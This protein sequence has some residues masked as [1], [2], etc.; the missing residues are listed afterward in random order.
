MAA[1]G[2]I[3]PFQGRRGSLLRQGCQLCPPAEAPARATVAPAMPAANAHRVSLD[4][5][6]MAAGK[7]WLPQASGGTMAPTSACW[8]LVSGG[9]A[10]ARR[11]GE[12]NPARSGESPSTDWRQVEFRLDLLK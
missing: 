5:M 8:G 12:A 2:A 7:L 9:S 4:V 3:M 6:A 11:A 1:R 10:V